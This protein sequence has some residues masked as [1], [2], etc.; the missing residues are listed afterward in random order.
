MFCTCFRWKVTLV[1]DWRKKAKFV[2][3]E[4]YIKCYFSKKKARKKVVYFIS[5]QQKTKI[6]GNPRSLQILPIFGRLYQLKKTCYHIFSF[7]SIL[8]NDKAYRNQLA[9]FMLNKFKF[10]RQWIW[11]HMDKSF[12]K[13]N[14]FLVSIILLHF[15]M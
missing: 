9:L 12:P 4:G 6:Y 14:F 8:Q 10:R 2:V 1:F 11:M 15:R 13:F 7:I 5:R 3:L